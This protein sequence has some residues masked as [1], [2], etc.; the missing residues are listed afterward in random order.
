M[1]Y[2]PFDRGALPVGVRTMTLHD[3][4]RR[5]RMVTVELWYPAA[6]RF[7][8]MDHEPGSC[9]RFQLAPGLP[10]AV[11]RAVRDAEPA[12]GRYPLILYS[13]GA[14]SHRREAALLAPHLA[15]RGYVIA[16]PDYAGDTVYDVL[17]D[18]A[19]VARTSPRR[20]D[21]AENIV[22]NRPLDAVFALDRVLAGDDPAIA[23]VI[24]RSRIAAC[25]I[26]LG[27]WTSMRLISL[28]RRPRAMFIV[29]PSW[30]FSGP[31][32]ETGVL[33]TPLA[34][35]D[36]WGR[37]VP[38]FLV[39]GDRDMLVILADLRELYR[40]L[41][42]PKRFAVLKNASHFHWVEN[43]E[44]LYE[45]YR[46]M[47]ENGTISVPGTD[48]VGL[49]RATPPFSAL[50]PNWH[51]TDTL[52]ALCLAHL[53]AELKDDINARAFLDR[54]LVSSFAARGIALESHPVSA[55]LNE[56]RR[57]RHEIQPV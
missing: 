2:N 36:D 29:A 6:A 37:D 17:A 34:R 40:R 42:R 23:E 49:A 3:E 26:S 55:P 27:G 25:G 13:H 57:C 24:D 43:A 51:G 5:G 45:S 44:A 33:Q 14:A 41:P 12:T 56:E 28:D 22:V 46:R 18:G 30:G 11:Q 32:P 20:R 31:F 19:D 47:W 53:D 4:S 7:R 48:V 21:V 1:S 52:N 38:T 39:A 15:S 9:D 16:A 50:C 10:E 8:G 54:D 35:L